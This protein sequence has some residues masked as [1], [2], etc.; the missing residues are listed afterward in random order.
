MALN[1]TLFIS[2]P[3]L[4]SNYKYFKKASVEAF[5]YI[6]LLGFLLESA[7]SI[8]AFFF[9][10]FLAG[11]KGD[12]AAVVLNPLSFIIFTLPYFIISFFIGSN[13]LNINI[14]SVEAEAEAEAKDIILS[15]LVIGGVLAE[16][17]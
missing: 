14:S 11:F 17:R 6:N 2:F 1:I 8:T 9:R 7:S 10:V 16:A 12:L 5:N 15:T 3:A 4:I 13:I